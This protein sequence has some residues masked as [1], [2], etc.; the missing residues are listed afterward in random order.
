ML[1]VSATIAAFAGSVSVL[2]VELGS[3]VP[4]DARML[5][6]AEKFTPARFAVQPLPLKHTV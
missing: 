4:H 2:A 1:Q 5:G 6:A 3:Y